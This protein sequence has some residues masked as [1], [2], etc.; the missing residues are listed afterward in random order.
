MTCPTSFYHSYTYI[1]SK[2]EILLFYIYARF[3]LYNEK[4]K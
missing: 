3:F 2:N 1:Y 4:L